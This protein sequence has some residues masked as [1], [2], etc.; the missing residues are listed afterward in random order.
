MTNMVLPQ[1]NGST[2]HPPS[3]WMRQTVQQFFG[4]FNWEN[5]PPEV[6]KLLQFTLSSDQPLSLTLKV[7]QFFAAIQWEGNSIAAMPQ[8]ESSAPSTSS[9]I[10]A[11]TLDD[12]SDLF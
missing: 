4:E 6:Q 3:V 11:F 1:T 7:G 5:N 8:P 12:F 10:D 9:P 2:L